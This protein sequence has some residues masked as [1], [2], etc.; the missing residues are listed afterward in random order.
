MAQISECLGLGV[1]RIR[2]IIQKATS[3][4]VS[5][6]EKL[7]TDYYKREWLS[8]KFNKERELYRET[9]GYRFVDGNYAVETTF[10]YW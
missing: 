6:D 3:R 5:L 9:N 4:A 2:S 8:L 10:G 7:K 1:D